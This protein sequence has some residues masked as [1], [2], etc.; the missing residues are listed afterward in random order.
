MYIII[1]EY[2]VK[3]GQE[4]EF[5]K[6]YGSNGDWVQLFKQA[7]GY[8]GTDL[9][10][11]VGIP[12]RYITIDRWISSTAYTTF[13]ENYDAAYEAMDARCEDLTEHEALIG[14]GDLFHLAERTRLP[15]RFLT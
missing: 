13:Q 8:L 12:R 2:I 6:T 15:N 7:D 1:W 4:T 3:I 9:L 14:A 10:H 5:E 11:D